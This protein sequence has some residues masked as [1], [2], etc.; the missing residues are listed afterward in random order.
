LTQE[1]TEF[2]SVHLIDDN[3]FKWGVTL[4]GPS[5]TPYE[6]CYYSAVLEFT[7]EY[8]NKPPKFYFVDNI[9]HPNVYKDGKVCISILNEGEDEFGYESKQER[10]NVLHTPHSI[11]MSIITLFTG[12]NLDSPA[13]VDAA[14]MYRDNIKLYRR[15]V[16]EYNDKKFIKTDTNTSRPRSYAI[17]DKA[18]QKDS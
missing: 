14:V 4:F 15:K 7:K 3:M 16:Q 6:N 18:T 13:N 10:W 12:P 11:I 9:F 8:P 17:W 5:G 2:Y 1:E